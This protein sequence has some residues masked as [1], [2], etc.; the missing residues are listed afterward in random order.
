MPMQRVSI[1]KP[2]DGPDGEFA[3][4]IG[5]D[6]H[7]RDFETGLELDLEMQRLQ[8]YLAQLDR[9]GADVVTRYYGLNGEP[10][11]TLAAIG[12]RWGVTRERARQLR[13]RAMD[14]LR[15]SLE[16]DCGVE[17]RSA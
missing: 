15:A 3:R 17:S 13:D 5:E 4:D 16:L 9:R 7:A 8:G 6:P 10:P 14:R 11:Q 12:K 1:D 2:A